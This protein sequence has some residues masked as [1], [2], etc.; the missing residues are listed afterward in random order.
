MPVE[1][2]LLIRALT[3][4][5]V[6]GVVYEPS[7]VIAVLEVKNPGSFGDA[8]LTFIRRAFGLVRPHGAD[9]R[10]HTHRSIWPVNSRGI[11]YG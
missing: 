4:A 9:A 1:F 11:S 7:Q 3:A 5:P 2:D 6:D 10:G 8:T